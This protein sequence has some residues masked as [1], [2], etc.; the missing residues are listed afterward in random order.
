LGPHDN[1]NSSYFRFVENR[2]RKK[3]DFTGVPLN[4]ITIRRP[5]KKDQSEKIIST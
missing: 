5:V 1:L 4:I 2:L 3:F